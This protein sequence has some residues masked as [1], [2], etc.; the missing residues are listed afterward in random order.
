[1]LSDVSCGYGTYGFWPWYWSGLQF[2]ESP[3]GRVG[4]VPTLPLLL[5]V[6]VQV[7]NR[8]QS[9]AHGAIC[10]TR[11]GRGQVEH[12]P[13]NVKSDRLADVSEG[14]L[15]VL[16]DGKGS[17]GTVIAFASEFIPMIWQPQ[18]GMQEWSR[19]NGRALPVLA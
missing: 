14:V 15:N 3:M 6:V 11:Q 10:V 7:D 5:T 16:V 2:L 1:M 9:S 17:P 12:A 4:E 19:S 13:H 8:P 18:C